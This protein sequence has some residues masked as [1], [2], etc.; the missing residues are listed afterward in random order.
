MTTAIKICGIK[1][2]GALDVAVQAGAQYVGFVYFPKS[3]R[4]ISLL[5]A[6]ALREKLP[7]DVKSVCVL[8]D[9]DDTLLADVAAILKPDF[10]QLHGAESPARVRAIRMFLPQ[11]KI[12]KAMGVRCGD[13]VAKAAGF[14]DC[15]DMLLFDAKAPLLPLPVRAGDSHDAVPHPGPLPGG[16]GIGYLPGG[17][18]LSFDWALLKGR[19]FMLPWALSGGLNAENI[20]EALAQTGAKMV[21]VSSGV[22]SAPGVKDA[23]LIQAFVKAVREYDAKS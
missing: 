21:D 9:A 15:A 19:E 5:E 11:M 7:A 22:E 2:V 1:D 18:G 3:P 12:I 14:T 6:A 17:N 13:D 8:V 16:E 20:H 23:A 10:V 4:H